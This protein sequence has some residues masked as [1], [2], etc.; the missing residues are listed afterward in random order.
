MYDLPVTVEVGGTEYAIRNKADYRTILDA[1]IVCNDPELT[2]QE[3]TISALIIFYEG[4]DDIETLFNTF[5]GKEE[6]ACS[7][8]GRFISC[9][10]E[11]DLGYKTNVKLIDW[12]QDEK[13]IV[14][15]VN[16]VA[17]TEIRALPY[18]HWWTFISYYLAIGECS[19]STVVG[20]R[21]KIAHGKKLEK[22]E[23]E[24]RRNN[25]QY[26]RWKNQ[27]LEE[28]AM[29]DSIWTYEKKE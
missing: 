11:E 23:Q 4:I 22:Y 6:E 5:L 15:A 20:I 2:Q 12:Q 1:L 27:E 16:N 29:L 8:M 13:L 26:F 10:E 14:S 7:A 17:G 28:K 9:G 18:L 3:R 19:L 21:D 25:P 24:F